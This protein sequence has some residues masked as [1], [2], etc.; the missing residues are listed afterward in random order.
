MYTIKIG[1]QYDATPCVAFALM[2]IAMQYDT[3]IDSD[4]ILVFSC[5]AFLRLVMKNLLEIAFCKLDTMQCKA[6]HHIL[7]WAL[8]SILSTIAEVQH[9]L[10]KL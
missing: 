10:L 2:L 9:V 6:L 7:N 1:S 4:Y 5:V 3:R 8:D